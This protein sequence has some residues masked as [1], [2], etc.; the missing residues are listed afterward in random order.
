M[1]LEREIKVGV[2]VKFRYGSESVIGVVKEDRGSIGMGGRRLYL[3]EFQAG[4]F[5]ESE[6]ELPAEQL[7]VQQHSLR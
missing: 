1:A 3:V 5:F 4:P 2:A 6:I 7:D